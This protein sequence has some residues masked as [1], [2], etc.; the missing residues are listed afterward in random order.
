M[1]LQRDLKP[2]GADNKIVKFADD[3]VCAVPEKSKVSLTCEYSNIRGWA[4]DRFLTINE[5]KTY[6]LIF[7]LSKSTVNN[8]LPTFS[9]IELVSSI[10]Y[11]GVVLSGNL[12]AVEHINVL[13]TLCYN[14]FICSNS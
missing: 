14:V 2:I 13:L 4:G 7:Y 1:I 11:L 3:T 9:N 6:E 8:L 10:K 5:I 12:S